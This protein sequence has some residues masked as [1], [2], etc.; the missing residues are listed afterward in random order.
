MSNNMK[1]WA[2]LLSILLLTGACQKEEL[3]LE[4]TYDQ[5]LT[6]LL[7]EHAEREG[8]NFFLMPATGDYQNLP[9]DPRN[10]VT[11]EKVQLGKLLYHE[12]GLALAPAQQIGAGTYSCASCHFAEAGF[13]AGRHQGIGEGGAGIGIKGE[14]RHKA[15][16]YQEDE[17]DVQPIRTPSSMNTAFQEVMLWN[18]QFGATGLNAGTEASWTPGTPIETNKLGYQGLETQAIAGLTVHRL[19][20]DTAFLNRT[21]YLQLF[22]KAFP[23]WPVDTRYSR[24]TAGLAIAAYERTLLANAAPFQQWLRGVRTAMSEQE[25]LGAIL[26]FG[27]AECVSCHTG[28]ALNSMTFY[29]LGMDDLLTCPE[30]TFKTPATDVAHLGRG[31]FTNRPE[32]MYKFKTPQLYNLAD[33]PFYGHGS[34]F[35][36]IRQ[37]V[38]YKNEARPQ[39]NSLPSG[40]L[41]REFVPLNLTDEEITAITAFLENA[42]YDKYLYRY[43]P[44]TLP[45][46]QCFPVN[47]PLAK[48]DLGCE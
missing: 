11:A 19:L 20:V 2:G 8:P 7:W 41:A 43:V 36:S 22:D 28:P 1:L 23:D 3:S 16:L 46:G 48:A 12:T 33:S 9:Q 14:G 27:K 35:R 10:P 44:E 34:S 15:D 24:E 17:L 26:F 45:S 18:G 25:K 47:D 6:A 40:Q 4:E 13:Q 37:V 38:E 42:L 30:P 29:A 39:K 5:D 21:G 31:G 32:D